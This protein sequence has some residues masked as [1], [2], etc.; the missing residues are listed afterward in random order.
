MLALETWQIEKRKEGISI[1]NWLTPGHSRVNLYSADE[2][3]A[4]LQA[5]FQIVEDALT[6]G[7]CLTLTFHITDGGTKRGKSS[8]VS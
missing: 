8:C 5:A 7:A 4:V 2:R 3:T 6:I 1:L